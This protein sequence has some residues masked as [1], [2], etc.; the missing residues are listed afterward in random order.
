M[1]ARKVRLFHRLQLAAHNTQKFADR[2]VSEASS[3]TTAQTAALMVLANKEGST[4]KEIAVALGVNESAITAMINR[5][6]KLGYIVRK[7]SETDKR[8]WTLSLTKEAKVALE[9]SRKPFGKVNK[10]I[11]NQLTPKEI[12]ALA[13]YLERIA[14]AFDGR[15]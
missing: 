14:K 1:S 10:I 2:L 6:L 11:E 12:E 15:D 7:R 4:Q 8:T 5:L 3:L 13:G 9:Q